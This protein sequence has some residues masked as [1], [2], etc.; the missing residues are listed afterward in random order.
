MIRLKPDELETVAGHIPEAEDA[1]QRARTT[2][3]WELSS[4]VM[5][6]PGVSTPAIEE[7]RDE[8]VHW[9]KRYEDKLNEAEELLYRTAA[10]M[11]QAD[12]TLADNMKELGLEFLGWYDVQRLFGEYDPVT[13]ERLSIGDRLLAG[14]MLLLSIVPPAKGAGVAG[15]AAIKGAKALDTASTLSKVKHV[16]RDDKMKAIGD[17]AFRQTVRSPLAETARLF[18]KQWDELVESVA[19]V[20]WQPAYAGVGPAPRVWMSGAR[21]E[22][23]DA[24]FHMIKKAEGEVV[25]KGTGE[26][27]TKDTY[28]PVSL[29]QLRLKNGMKM[30][31]NDAL[32]A[33]EKFLG[34]GYKDMGNGRFVSTDGTRVVRMGDGDIL[35]K[36]GGGPHMNFETLVP[37]PSKPGKMKVDQNLHIYLEE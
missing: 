19:S 33:A 22:V 34:P 35:G 30:K 16:V 5:N 31:I 12:Q 11:R 29:N 13:G 21:N 24:T 7:L 37:N 9:L 3:S 18:K 23:K 28:K 26:T 17:I 8:L 2:L 36:H 4:L 27:V 10:A 14:G 25:G 20:S 15:K 6:L 1:C 32:E